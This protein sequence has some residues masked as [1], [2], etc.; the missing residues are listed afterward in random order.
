MLKEIT[1]EL[2][3]PIDYAHKGNMATASFLTLSAPTSRNIAECAALKQAFFRALPKSGQPSAGDS[4]QEGDP[5]PEDITAMLA[6]SKDVEYSQVLL[7]MRDLLPHVA[8]VD[9]E[10]RMTRP[11]VDSM[12]PEDL[13]LVTGVYLLNFILASLLR[14]QKGT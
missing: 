7:T 5:R 12:S 4:K 11:L 9:G 8:K 2:K 10:E 1:Y 14:S 3:S 13:E 6:S